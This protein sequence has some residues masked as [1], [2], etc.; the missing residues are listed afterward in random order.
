MKAL[1]RLVIPVA[2]CLMV[3]PIMATPVQAAGAFHVSGGSVD[4]DGGYVGDEVRIYGSWAG[5]HGSYIYIYY[6][7]Y[8]EDEDDWPHEKVRYEE[9]DDVDDR[10][11]FDYDLMI[12]ESCSGEH[13]ILI[14]DD[15]DPDDVVDTVE[16]TVYPYIE[17]DEEKGP[18]GTEVKVTGFGW[19]ENESDIEIRFYLEDPDDDYDD[20]DLYVVAGSGDIE[21]DTD[22][23]HHGTWKD[24]VSFKVPSASSGDH[25]VYAV[26]DENDD[27]ADNN[28]KGVE[29]EV[30]PGIS[31][32]VTKGSPGDTATVSGSG[33]D[34]DERDIRVWF[35]DE[36]VAGTTQADDDGC[37]EISF[38]VP[39]AAMGKYDVTA[40]GNKTKKKDIEELEFEVT[41]RVGLSPETGHVGTSLTV[42]GK[43]FPANESVTIT[44]DGVT[45]GSGTTS[46]KGSLSGVSFAAEHSQTTHTTDHSVVVT[47]DATT[48]SFTFVMESESPAKPALSSP[49]N[50]TRLG[51]V[52]K[53]TPVFQWQTVDDP[54]GVSYDLQIGTTPAFAQVLI[55]KTGL[56]DASYGLTGAEALGYGSYYWRVRA[57]DGAKNDS[58]WTTPYSF[59]SGLLPL[60]AVIAI[61][62]AIA[63]LIGALVF[64]L[65]RKGAPYD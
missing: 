57:V 36:R 23:D 21:I 52:T 3:V 29:F 31:L 1:C 15:D 38:T 10:Y 59:K 9:Y 8:D 28:I 60:W 53:V 34:D 45:K 19:D 33:F 46:S 20:D 37:W 18:E 2:I 63:A 49:A 62:A 41:S 6:E 12:P 4:S 55:S 24:E 22:I 48:V 5:I 50:A 47:Y 11:E 64:F 39:E 40:E 13:D 56:T 14:C 61:A 44:Y 42:S 26:G 7:L 16:F 30:E 32:E 58:G 43:G 25:W 27:I 51:L 17:I 65:T 35:G 54:S